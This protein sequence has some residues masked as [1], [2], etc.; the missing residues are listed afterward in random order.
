[1][2]TDDQSIE[3]F[4]DVSQKW[5]DGCRYGWKQRDDGQ[6]TGQQSYTVRFTLLHE[7]HKHTLN[8]PTSGFLRCGSYEM[9]WNSL[10]LSLRPCSV[11]QQLR[12]THLFAAISTLEELHD[13]L[14]KSTTVTYCC[15]CRRRRRHD[16]YFIATF[17]L[18]LTFTFC[19]R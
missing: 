14:Y 10:S 18:L 3:Y 13:A 4:E 12:E 1:M 11:Y 8:T 6:G 17:L 9:K 19:P 2:G 15:C 5:N 16:Y 7:T